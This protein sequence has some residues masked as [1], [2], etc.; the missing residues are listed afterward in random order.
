MPASKRPKRG[1]TPLAVTVDDIRAARVQIAGSILPT[2]LAH[3]NVLSEMAGCEVWLKLENLQFTASFKERGALTKLKSLSAAERK[4]GVVAASAGNHA[5]GVA[6]AAQRLGIPATIVMPKGTPFTKISRTEALGAAIV[7]SGDSLAEAAEHAEALRAEK[8]LTLV[9][10]YDDPLVIAGQGTIALEVLEANDTFDA[11]IVPIG[12]GGLISGIAIGAK[13]LKPDIEIVGVEAEL[14]PSM[15]QALR[16]KVPEVGGQ[17]IADGI[18][19]KIPGSLTKPI[20]E[21]LVDDI[22]LVGEA[23]IEQAVQTLIEIEKTVTEGAGAAALAGLFANTA[24]FA[25]KRVCV[26]VSGGNID[27]RVLAS[28]LMRGLVR[29]GRLIRIRVE[30]SDAPGALARVA[31]L[32]GDC[33]GNIVEIYHQRLFQDVPVKLADL[34][35]VLET[36]DRDH[37]DTIVGALRE[38][39]FE[40]RLLSS[41]ATADGD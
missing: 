31:T 38:A 20:V 41:M 21:R 5:Q 37:V 14:Y 18:A 13:S 40:T 29:E 6:F 15:H 25:G 1:E 26:I 30:I 3:S 33:G 22:L 34:D 35:V 4:A 10:P 7:L 8:G 2:P 11:I 39:G 32:I 17:T 24:R 27:A 12:G 16:G 36:R 19:V 23:A 9:H 28:I